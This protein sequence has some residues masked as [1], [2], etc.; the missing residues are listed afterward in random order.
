MLKL[1][2]FFFWLV[3]ACVL[4]T[5]GHMGFVLALYGPDIRSLDLLGNSIIID[6]KRNA[7]T[8]IGTKW[9]YEDET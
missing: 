8:I 5:F 1:T 6:L 7:V 4:E 3:C 9:Y 2:I